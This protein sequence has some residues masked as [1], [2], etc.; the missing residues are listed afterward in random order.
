MVAGDAY[1]ASEPS[2]SCNIMKY[3][4]LLFIS[5]FISACHNDGL[6]T[7]LRA[8]GFHLGDEQQM[9]VVM[10]EMNSLNIPY[11]VEDDGSIWYMQKDKA[12]VLGII[13]KAKYGNTLGEYI[14][15]SV[16]AINELEK[17]LIISKLDER[18]IPYRINNYSGG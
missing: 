5:I 11:K 15:E 6:P 18:K 7:G 13:R 10:A 12:E 2:V 8:G 16:V 1:G 4:Y 14:F 17:Q 9:Q 3:I